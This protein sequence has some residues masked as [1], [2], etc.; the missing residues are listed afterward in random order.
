MGRNSLKHVIQTVWNN[1]VNFNNSNNVNIFVVFLTN[2]IFMNM[3]FLPL[4]AGLLLAASAQAQITVTSN[5]LVYGV[6]TNLTH[7]VDVDITGMVLPSAG[8]SQLWDY[9]GLD[10][11][12]YFTFS[13][14]T[15]NLNA[16]FASSTAMFSDMS[17]DVGDFYVENVTEYFQQNS[18][19]FSQLGY[20]I[21][22]QAFELNV[23][24]DSLKILAQDVEFNGPKVLQNFDIV[25]GNVD[26]FRSEE[27]IN[28]QLDYL[29]FNNAPGQLK[30]RHTGIFDVMGN[31]KVIMPITGDTVEALLVKIQYGVVDSIFVNNMPIPGNL[32]VNTGLE[33]G[34]VTV[35]NRYVLVGK[36]YNSY[37]ANIYMDE[38][39]TTIEGAD[40]LYMPKYKTEDPDTGVSVNRL[41][42][43]TIKAYPNPTTDKLILDV[44]GSKN[45]KAE[46]YNLAG[47]LV[48]QELV[49]N[50]SISVQQLPTGT[51][52]VK[53]V[54][55]NK[56]VGVL[57]FIKQ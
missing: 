22:Y 29:S 39:N 16:P 26:T 45:M 38:T 47:Q 41:E 34:M 5:D 20:N 14:E 27:V 32:L 15:S 37:L 19:S 21:P 55:N 11:L 28:F 49:V 23:P 35:D 33:Q 9:S 40:F 42:L 4:A 10:S 57:K 13:F 6:D 30:R 1:I 31:G 18:S 36:G 2:S 12:D 8:A 52:N 3:K 56:A 51:Y 50:K 53:V 7:V 54:E 24:G 44:S 46:I 48:A 25:F 17:F 43:A